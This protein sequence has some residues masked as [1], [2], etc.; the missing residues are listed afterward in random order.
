MF[1]AAAI[2]S[3]R[4]L[5]T[6]YKEGDNFSG[7]SGYSIIKVAGIEEQNIVDEKLKE[8]EKFY[9]VDYE[10]GFIMLK[11]TEKELEKFLDGRK[12]QDGKLTNLSSENIYKRIDA[13]PEVTR[14]R[15]SRKVNISYELRSKFIESAQ[16]SSLIRERVKQIIAEVGIKDNKDAYKSKLQEKPF[17]SNMY[18]E[19]TGWGYY[20]MFIGISSVLSAIT[21]GVIFSIRRR[22]R[23]ARSEYEELFIEFPE[24]ERDLDILLREAQYIDEGLKVLIYKD[25]L[26]VYKGVFNFEPLRDIKQLEFR[27]VTDSKG[28]FKG[29]VLDIL[30]LDDTSNL[31]IKIGM[32]RKETEQH[33]V[34]LGNYIKEEYKKRVGYRF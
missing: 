26:I 16:K 13:I 10:H 11:A 8:D 5:E 12:L 22:I 23:H 1:T 9:L 24:T 33:I 3:F 18:L 14:G 31:D 28:R 6:L 30:R 34:Q 15:R 2:N 27:K 25:S 19:T 4:N 7:D 17:Y 20:G 29:Y 32:I 21:I